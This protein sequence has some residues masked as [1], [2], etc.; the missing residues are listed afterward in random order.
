MVCA[1]TSILS[2]CKKDR[3]A[4]EKGLNNNHNSLAVAG[5]GKWDLLGYGYDI[6]GDYLALESASKAPILDMVRFEKDY[7]NR[8]NNPT[9][10]TGDHQS[11]YG[12]TAHEYVKDVNNKRKFAT[13]V[14]GATKTPSPE[15]KFPF[16]GSL[17]INNTNHN[18]YNFSSNYSYA[19]YEAIKTLKKLQFTDDVGLDLLMNYLTPEFL[20]NIAN[21][22]AEALVGMYGTHVLLD[23][24][25]G[26]RM[27][28]DFKGSAIKEVT[29]ETKTRSVEGSLGF[30]VKKFGI[31]FSTT[32]STE[33]MTRYF[34]ESRERQF[35]LKFR[36]GSTSG[37]SVSFDSNGNTSENINIGAWEQSVNEFNCALVDIEKAVPIYEFIADPIK[38]GQMKAAIEKYIMDRQISLLPTEVYEFYNPIKSKHAYSLNSQLNID[39]PTYGLNGQPFKAYPVPYAGAVPVY[40]FL[41]RS[42]ED[43]VLTTNRNANWSGFTYDGIIFYAFTTRVSGS[44]PIYEFYNPSGNHFYST[45][46]NAAVS[47]PG[48]R[49]NGIQFY[50]YPN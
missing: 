45:N 41:N 31:N 49:M 17:T 6:T 39:H 40:Q 20:N 47:Y 24:T 50:A 10:G 18:I 42:N 8:I 34:N 21:Y 22:N 48:W 9:T 2:S 37:R 36:G 19:R 28:F 29:T 30:F 25:L 27:T 38:K 3:F 23:I 1:L 4:E 33:E 15:G 11:Y 14:T 32:L 13:T 43:H 44:V 5:D 16:T 46:I 12:A 26:G 35:G 7:R